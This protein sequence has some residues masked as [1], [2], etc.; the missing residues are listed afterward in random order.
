MKG[1]VLS[2]G[3]PRSGSTWL[4]NLLRLLLKR[5]QAED[6]SFFSGWHAAR[7]AG[8]QDSLELLKLHKFDAALAAEAS[9]VAYSFR[10]PRDALASARRK[11]GTPLELQWLEDCIAH[12]QAWTAVAD[13]VLRYEAMLQDPGQQARALAGRLGMP[14]TEAERACA[15]IGH[16]SYES[17]GS[18][19]EQ[20]HDVN[21]FHRNHR[22]SD[23][24]PGRWREEL[25][26]ALLAEFRDRHG[27]W[28]AKHGYPLT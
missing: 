5:Q 24:R 13:H 27:D 21:L 10:D 4:Y 8:R 9:F 3:M 17:A 11:F 12:H 15:E 16:L 6:G 25:P 1:L 2:A 28:L 7:Q 22:T 14:A 26:A 20:F 23:G 18:R 19:N